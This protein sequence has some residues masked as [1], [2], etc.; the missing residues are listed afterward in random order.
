MRN[1]NIAYFHLIFRRTSELIS[2]YSLSV[3]NT[4]PCN[5][6]TYS[7]Y[8]SNFYSSYS[9]SVYSPIVFKGSYIQ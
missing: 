1:I 8:V 2:G 4:F 7:H 6:K 3:I 9:N 5:S